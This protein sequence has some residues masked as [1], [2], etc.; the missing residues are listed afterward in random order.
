[1]AAEPDDLWAAHAVLHAMGAEGRAREG[2]AWVAWLEPRFDGGGDFVRHIH[3]HRAL[4]HLD[5]GQGEAALELYDRRVRDLPHEGTRDIMNAASLLWRIE[6]AGTPA[7]AHRWDDLA[8]IAERRIGDHAWAFADLHY[9]LSLGAAG[10]P[11]RVRAF[12]AGVA[13]R[14]REGVD[15]QAE[16][17]RVVGHDVAL[18]VAASLGGD[19]REAA[20][21]LESLAGRLP[22]LGGSEAQRDLL[23]RIGAKAR[24]DSGGICHLV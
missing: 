15:S 24:H 17:F 12:L 23:R 3:W 10:R 8:D 20:W 9:L 16:V 4:L 1:V 7:G 11:D 5:L 14:M 19:P 13:H 22:R 6:A 18:A 21:L 2:I